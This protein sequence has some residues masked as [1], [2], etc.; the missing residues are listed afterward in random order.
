MEYPISRQRLNAVDRQNNQ[1]GQTG[2]EK[3][4]LPKATRR[5]ETKLLTRSQSQFFHPFVRNRLI[6]RK[7]DT[8]FGCLEPSRTDII[9]IGSKMNLTLSALR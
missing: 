7:S 4:A 1:F 2:S 3:P 6:D 9:G 8:G 5:L